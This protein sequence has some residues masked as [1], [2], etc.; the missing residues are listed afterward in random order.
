MAAGGR[1]L[2]ISHKAGRPWLGPDSDALYKVRLLC[3]SAAS[4]SSILQLAYQGE[5]TLDNYQG[6]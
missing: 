5:C 1:Y 2:H 3:S 6:D 4:L